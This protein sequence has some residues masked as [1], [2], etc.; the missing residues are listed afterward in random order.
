MNAH[1]RREVT[2]AEQARA[3][4]TL[5]AR[6]CLDTAGDIEAA[7]PALLRRIA[8]D[9]ALMA[10]LTDGHETTLARALLRQ[11]SAHNRA[12]RYMLKRLLR[13]IWQEWRRITP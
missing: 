10:A 5:I 12:M 8:G 4:L 2:A 13:D 3:D 9:T 6:D 11:I 1:T 7:V